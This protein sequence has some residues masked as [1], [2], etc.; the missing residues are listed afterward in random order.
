MGIARIA[1]GSYVGTGNCGVSNPTTVEVGFTPKFFWIGLLEYTRAQDNVTMEIM[2]DTGR[3]ATNGLFI[4]PATRFLSSPNQNLDYYVTVT[5]GSRMSWYGLLES[6]D[7]Y[8]EYQFNEA[9]KTYYWVAI[10]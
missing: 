4:Y 3:N 10:G 8:G 9:G 1:T 7:K 5:W 6:P 2:M